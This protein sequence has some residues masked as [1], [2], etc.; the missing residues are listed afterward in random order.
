[1]RGERSQSERRGEE[2]EEDQKIKKG[3]FE[4]TFF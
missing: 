1:V 4:N 3:V 2:R